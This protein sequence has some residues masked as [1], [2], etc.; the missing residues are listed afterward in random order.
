[1]ADKIKI[2]GASWVFSDSI[3]DSQLA[4]DYLLNLGHR[5][6]AYIGPKSSSQQVIPRRN[7]F[8]SKLEEADCT[9]PP[10]HCFESHLGDISE[11][12][13]AVHHIMQ[14]SPRP[15]AFFCAFDI[16]AIY[17]IEQL[18]KDGFRIPQDVS[19]IG[20]SNTESGRHC[21]PMLTTVSEDRSMIGKT[22]AKLLLDTIEKKIN[23]PKRIHLPG[24][25][26]VRESTA[27]PHR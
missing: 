16:V 19:V 25:L 13:N 23:R 21:F 9:P 17:V 24:E 27:P 10:F 3:H 14:S 20:M 1:M 15:T 12:A 5:K 7:A 8:Y 4:M 6:I 18:R 11:I 2:M 22:A 26:I